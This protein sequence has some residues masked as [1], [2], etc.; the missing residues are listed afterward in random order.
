MANS[1]IDILDLPRSECFPKFIHTEFRLTL[2]L[3]IDIAL[4]GVGNIFTQFDHAFSAVVPRQFQCAED[5]VR[6]HQ[7]FQ[8]EGQ[9]LHLVAIMAD[10]R[11]HAFILE[12]GQKKAAMRQ[13]ALDGVEPTSKQLRYRDSW[14]QAHRDKNG[15]PLFVTFSDV[16]TVQQVSG[17]VI[18]SKTGCEGTLAVGVSAKPGLVR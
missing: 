18:A 16:L 4:V 9:D 12:E 6:L 15:I 7:A 11:D 2:R 14:F 17:P 1:T 13:R 8:V 3:A 10:S 5:K